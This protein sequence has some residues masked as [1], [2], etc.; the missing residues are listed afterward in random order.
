MNNYNKNK[1]Y[2]K[3][4]KTQNIQKQTMIL[5]FHQLIKKLKAK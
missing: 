3:Y 5:T 2:N 1:N 4:Q